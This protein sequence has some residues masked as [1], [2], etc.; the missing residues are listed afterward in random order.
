MLL[1]ALR[2]RCPMCGASA[3]WRRWGELVDHCPGCGWRFER[4]EGYWVGA[5]IVNH[6]FAL[7]AVLVYLVGGLIYFSGRAPTWFIFASI[8][9]ILLQGFWLYPTSKTLWVWID[10]R[11]HP[12]GREEKPDRF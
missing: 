7:A 10:V 2:K 11:L 1:R 3:I 5:M 8:G 4:E 6:A 12:Y 9:L